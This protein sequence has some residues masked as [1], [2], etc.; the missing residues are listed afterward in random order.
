MSVALAH[1]LRVAFN[2]FVTIVMTLVLLGALVLVWAK[3]VSTLTASIEKKPP[4]GQ[5]SA[6]VWQ[7]RVFTTDGQLRRYLHT[8]GLSYSRWV[9]R[10]PAA[11]AVLQA[12]PAK[13]GAS[14]VG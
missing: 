5:P 10:H 8:K 4:I 6:V 13:H 2:R 3:V 1:G 11:F 14:A 7:N 9:S 12:K